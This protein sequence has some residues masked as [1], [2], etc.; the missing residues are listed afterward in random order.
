MLPFSRQKIKGRGKVP[1]NVKKSGPHFLPSCLQ[2]QCREKLK[3]HKDFEFV[4][5]DNYSKCTGNAALQSAVH[6]GFQHHT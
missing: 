3:S 2:A 1:L 4:T 6:H 5:C